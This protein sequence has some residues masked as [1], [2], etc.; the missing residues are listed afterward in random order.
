MK[1]AKK[2]DKNRVVD[3]LMKS[4]KDNSRLRYLTR[5]SSRKEKYMRRVF[6]YSFNFALKRNGVYLSDSGKGVAICYNSRYKRKRFSDIL[7]QLKLVS[8]ALALNKIFEIFTHMKKVESLK[9]KYRD[10]LHL[11][12]FGVDPEESP[13]TSAWEIS[14]EIINLADEKGLDI[15]IETTAIQNKKVYERFGFTVY[16]KWHES[17]GDFDIWLMKREAA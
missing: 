13:R 10:Y 3:I 12:Y 11:W 17:K 4:F 14:K 1:K 16:K 5:N 6:E 9:P 2:T 7:G 8:C 15:F